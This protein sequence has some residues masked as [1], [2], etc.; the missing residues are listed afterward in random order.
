MFVRTAKYHLLSFE[1]Q[2]TVPLSDSNVLIIFAIIDKDLLFSLSIR[3]E[4]EIVGIS[5]VRGPIASILQ[6]EH[7]VNISFGIVLGVNRLRARGGFVH[8]HWK[9]TTGCLVWLSGLVIGD[10]E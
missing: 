8:V 9:V 7:V 4:H 1:G 6:A 5:D 3:L 10:I 2:F